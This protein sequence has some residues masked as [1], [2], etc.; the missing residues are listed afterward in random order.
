MDRV[1]PSTPYLDTNVLIGALE[2]EANVSRPIH[3]FLERLLSRRQQAVTSEL[4]IAEILAP[5]GPERRPIDE[6]LRQDYMDIL[7]WSGVI[8]LVTVSRDVLYETAQFR[9][10]HP[11]RLGLGDAIHLVTATKTGCGYFVTSDKDIRPPTS[12]R[13][14]RPDEFGFA[15]IL[16]APS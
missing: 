14:I 15:A 8:S 2:G 13:L 4:T 16:G 10:S 9:A 11:I 5:R 1:E 12:I 6:D 7:I 3:A